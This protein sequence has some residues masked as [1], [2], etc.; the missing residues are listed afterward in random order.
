MGR[1]PEH[2]TTTKLRAQACRLLE[3]A[4][5]KECAVGGGGHH[6]EGSEG[7]VVGSPPHVA[8]SGRMLDK[9]ERGKVGNVEEK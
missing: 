1:S 5:E 3:P 6:E 7:P 8:H 2:S 4:T 9:D